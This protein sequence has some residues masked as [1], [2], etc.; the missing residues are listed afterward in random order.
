VISLF[1]AGKLREEEGKI[2]GRVHELLRSRKTQEARA[3]IGKLQDLVELRMRREEAEDRI[4]EFKERVQGELSGINRMLEKIDE[5]EG[6][7]KVDE[8]AV[9]RYL[10]IQKK[11]E[12]YECWRK[13]H[14]EYLRN[15]PILFLFANPELVPLGFPL[16]REK[17]KFE[18]FANFIK[19]EPELSELSAAA[20]LEMGEQSDEKVAHFVP[21]VSKFKRLL[22]ENSAYL[23]EIKELEKSEFLKADVKNARAVYKYA[24]R[25]NAPPADVLEEIAELGEAKLEMMRKEEERFRKMKELR[26]SA[27]P[28]EKEKLAARKRELEGILS[29]FTKDAGLKSP[30]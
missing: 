10:G 23:W 20:L 25:E 5:L 24:V 1:D 30:E 4:R 17:E 15:K 28:D 8:E 9:R 21:Q 11:L 16:P 12:E 29:L 6:Y 7:G 14:I 26:A 13:E 19:S 27:N 3:E 2:F 22:R 18:E